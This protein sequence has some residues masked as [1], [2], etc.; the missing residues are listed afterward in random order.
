M[1]MMVKLELYQEALLSNLAMRV[2]RQRQSCHHALAWRT[3]LLFQTNH[4]TDLYCA[5]YAW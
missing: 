2:N 3:A 1:D 4:R 5:W